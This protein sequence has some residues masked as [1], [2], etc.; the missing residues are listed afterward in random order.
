MDL[1]D[2][3]LGSA[4]HHLRSQRPDIVRHTQGSY[5][6][7]LNPSDPAG[8]TLGE[9]ALIAHHV[10]FLSGHDALA[11]HYGELL[12]QREPALA[13]TESPR[14]RAILDHVA[15]VTATPGQATQANIQAL[16]NAGLTPR[17]VVAL[18]QII[19]FVSYQVRAAFGLSLLA[20]E[21]RT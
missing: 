21:P 6:V 12:D 2:N 15:L 20:S 13:A 18:T 4:L 8:L 11:R 19:A 16:R 9:R 1:L 3:I 17:D 7:L 10:A 14:L 5:E